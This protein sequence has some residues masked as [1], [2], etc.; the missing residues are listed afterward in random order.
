MRKAMGSERPFVGPVPVC[1]FPTG[2]A[3]RE[4]SDHMKHWDS[5]SGLK[6]AKTL[7]QGPSANKTREL[8]RLNR[9]E[10]RWVVGLLTENS[11]L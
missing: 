7:I 1:G 3:K 2:V 4:V 11:H 6:E 5:L 8:L 9:N 10:L